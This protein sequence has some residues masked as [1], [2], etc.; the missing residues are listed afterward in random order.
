MFSSRVAF[1]VLICLVLVTPSWGGHTLT[2]REQKILATW[3]ARHQQFRAATDF[4]IVVIDRSK[5]FQ[6]FVLLVF[7]GPFG[8]KSVSPAFVQSSLG[9]QGHLFFG[10][11]RPKPY[12]L[13][14]GP[15]E[16]D[17]T[18]ILIPRGRTYELQEGE[19]D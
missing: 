7:N 15:F 19:G 11:P 14:I 1:G 4:A 10:P 6:N 2:S 9:L 5:S 13:V 17:N 12:R 18:E 8:S 16:S 3:L